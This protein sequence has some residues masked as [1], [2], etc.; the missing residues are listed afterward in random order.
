[1]K[2]RK[3]SSRRTLIETG[4]A[5][6][7]TAALLLGGYALT[8]SVKQ[9]SAKKKA[10]QMVKLV[11]P[12]PPPKPVE[13]PPEPEIKKDVPEEQQVVETPQDQPRQADEGPPPGEDLGVDAE[14]GA[15]SDAFGLVGR[16]GGR[17]LISGGAGGGTVGLMQKYGWYVRLLE[18]E[19]GRQMAKKA[20]LPGGGQQVY[21][22]IVLD[23]EGGI[24]SHAIYGSSGNS[25]VDSAVDQA[26]KLVKQ[27]SEPPPDGMPRTLKIRITVPA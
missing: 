19:I 15:G 25:Q 11:S 6:S 4:V 5:L 3:K 8:K 26:L 20:K 21:V 17:D 13:K 23:G 1:M 24:V 16:K 14:G 27:V 9:D 22:R 2:K 12:P 18:E 10:V 7:L